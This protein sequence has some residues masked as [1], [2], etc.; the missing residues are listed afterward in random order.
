MNIHEEREEGS[1][2]GKGREGKESLLP[3]VASSSST[4]DASLHP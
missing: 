2:L 1:G 3:F 4:L